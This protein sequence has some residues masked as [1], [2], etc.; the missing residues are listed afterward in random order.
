[1][2]AMIEQEGTVAQQRP[3]AAPQLRR[4]LQ[5]ARGGAAVVLRT[6]LAWNGSYNQTDS[7]GT[8]DPDVAAWQTFKDELQGRAL[9]PLGAAGPADR[10]W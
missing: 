10:G 8:V 5:H 1:M 7:S 4:A 3:L 9:A 2:N 6:I